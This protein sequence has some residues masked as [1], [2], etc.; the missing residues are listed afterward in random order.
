MTAIFLSIITIGVLVFFVV[1]RSVA[2]FLPTK[3]LRYGTAIGYFLQFVGLAG[4][5]IYHVEFLSTPP[6]KIE[7]G[8]NSPD[9]IRAIANLLW[10]LSAICA[11]FWFLPQILEFLKDPRKSVPLLAAFSGK[12]SP[13]VQQSFIDS[14]D[15]TKLPQ[16]ANLSD[17]H[18]ELIKRYEGQL[19]RFPPGEEK[20]ILLIHAAECHLTAEFERLYNLIFGS[21]IQALKMLETNCD[22][23]VSSFFESHIQL[24]EDAPTMRFKTLSEWS[25]LLLEMGIVSEK[26][27]KY[28]IT[29]KGKAFLSFLKNRNYLLKAF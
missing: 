16:Y 22:A 2:K 25:R 13:Y 7:F 6:L 1:N 26:E 18:K 28:S 27:N 20:S 24:T 29:N 12:Q 21:Q 23:N 14:V 11:V 4:L 9:F 10:P 15:I 17:A 5:T 19:N 8:A 3:R